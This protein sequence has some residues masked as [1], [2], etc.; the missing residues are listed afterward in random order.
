M[1]SWPVRWTKCA[2][3]TG[4]WEPWE[5]AALAGIA[6][7]TPDGP[8]RQRWTLPGQ[9]ILWWL[10][11]AGVSGYNLK[12][13]TRSGG[14]YTTIASPT[15]ASYVDAAPAPGTVFFYVVSAV[16]GGVESADSAEVSAPLEFAT[17]ATVRARISC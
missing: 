15:T 5:I 14:P 17:V 1:G 12:R 4:C 9:I 10:A 8:V 3:M 2:F 16:N 13:A 7:S 6:P 11:C